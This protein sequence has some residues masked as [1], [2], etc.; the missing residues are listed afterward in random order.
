MET[1]LDFRPAAN[2]P[3]RENDSPHNDRSSQDDVEK[4]SIRDHASLNA[5]SPEHA[6]QDPNIVDW[7]G[8]EDSE[9]PMN[10]SSAKKITAITIVST[11][12][13]LSPL[14]STITAPASGEIMA[15][16]HS[17]N[18]TIAVFVTSVYLLGY[19]FGPLVLAPLSELYGR[20][21]VY[22]TCNFGFVIWTV[23]C[24]LSN[25]LS[26][27]IVFR[28]LAGVA[29]S[30]PPTIGAGSVADM[31]PL[32][33]RGM[34]MM[35]WIMGPVLGP[36]VGPLIAGYLTHAK[37]WRWNFW[38]VSILAGAVFLLSLLFLKESHAPTILARKTKRLRKE[39]GN[40]NL[41]SALDSGKD[42]K[43]LFKVSIVRPL[44][45]LFLSP[46]VL[47]LSLYMATIYGYQYL[48]FTT[49]PR[50]FEGQY[51]FTDSS[52]GLVYLGIGV[53]FLASLVISGMASDRLVK[54]LT[55]RNGGIA[56]PE[57]R[58]PL[59]FVGAVLAPIGLFMYGWTAEEKVQWIAPI[60]GSAMLG[61]A[62]FF[63][64]VSRYLVD[65][66]TIYAA[67]AS[68][69]AIVSRSLLGALLP[70]AGNIMYNALGI[71]WGTSLLG[72][73]AVAFAPVPLIFW[74][75]GERIRNSGL[76][77]VKF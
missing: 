32:Q 60:I 36:S 21:I 64:I 55:E 59:L 38:L 43:E 72:F 61:G 73:I 46:I 40:P 54:Y 12:S 7:E 5:I 77:Q 28:F 19:V 29:G 37:G 34:A 51:G 4:Q 31:I 57:Y 24:A 22:N 45:M 47:L 13:F 2:P 3:W 49:F 1:K 17:T 74:K 8:P 14:G 52:I 41:R 10:W 33:K 25:N 27:L 16:F 69:A 20:S 53:G 65:A 48:M 30:A 9:N 6:T 63:I 26:A 62:G 18:E 23:A 67:S 11:L 39:T 76:S 35:G 44:K 71:G 68:A 42:P 58:L 50:V 66:Y 56:K 15:T 70:L 75:F